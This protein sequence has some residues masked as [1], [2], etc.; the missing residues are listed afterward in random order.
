MDAMCPRL[1]E[2]GGPPGQLGLGITLGNPAGL[3]AALGEELAG[4]LSQFCH[5]ASMQAQGGNV[6]ANY[7][8]ML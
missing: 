3:A 2:L 8:I 1:A 6:N 4:F 7:A 5:V